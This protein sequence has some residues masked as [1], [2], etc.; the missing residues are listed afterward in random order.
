MHA[1]W[2]A[3]W[4]KIL[5]ALLV[6]V[7]LVAGCATHTP[8]VTPTPTPTATPTPTPTPTAT[9][10]PTPAPG[11]LYENWTHGFSFRYPE[12]WA[13]AEA[14]VGG[15]Q[16]GVVVASPDGKVTAGVQAYYFAE[17]T[18]LEKFMDWIMSQSGMGVTEPPSTKAITL[19]DGT[20][21]VEVLIQGSYTGIERMSKAVCV[22][23]ETQGLIAYGTAGVA[24]WDAYVEEIDGLLNSFR[25][26]P[27]TGAIP[28]P[29]PTPA[30]TGFYRNEEYGFSISY[31]A[32]WS[33]MPVSG[34]GDVFSVGAPGYMPGVMVIVMPFGGATSAAEVG[35]GFMEGMKGI[36]PDVE[37]VSQGEVSLDDGTPAYEIV[38]IGT[39]PSA[40][41]MKLECKI[42]L[43]LR[44]EQ[45]FMIE[46][47]SMP[48]MFAGQEDVIDS[49]LYSFHLE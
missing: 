39:P 1:T 20:P 12:G 47:Y 26:L 19:A 23:R 24:D 34:E 46:G 13:E 37:V 30:G 21:A 45:S 22:L 16:Q 15:V 7:A 18:T 3:D 5:G 43:V 32:S 4:W 2:K 38:Y 14:P 31:P 33:E 25:L 29:T 6:V 44:G 28:T 49:V 35:A 9:P 41:G 48:E 27:F 42:L 8:T 36:M 40:M 10:T 11:T 17:E